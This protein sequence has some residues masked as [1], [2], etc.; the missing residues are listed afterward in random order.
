MADTKE[1]S[2]KKDP[3]KYKFGESELDLKSYI[4]NLDHNVQRY[5]DSKNW[6]EG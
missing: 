1:K 3:V 6:N 4:T 2:E 5:M